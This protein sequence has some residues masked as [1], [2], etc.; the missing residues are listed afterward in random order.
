[1]T[2]PES[3][4]EMEASA[5]TAEAPDTTTEAPVSAIDIPDATEA[6]KDKARQPRPTDEFEPLRAK[7]REK[8]TVQARVVKWQKNGLDME[9]VDPI[10]DGK[11][12]PSAPTL[13]APTL[14]AFMSNDNIDHDPNRN[15][16]HYFGKTL[17]VKITSVKAKPGA[18]VAE[19]TLSHRAVLDEEARVAGH[20]AVKHLNVGDVIEVKVKNFD[21][22]NVKVDL[23]HGI[24]AVILLRDLSWQKVDH[25]YEI[26]KRGETVTAKIL[27]LDRGRREVRLGIRQLTA[28]PEFAMYAEYALG[29]T[30]KAKVVGI[31]HFGAEIELPNGLIA[32]IPISEIDWQRIGQVSEVLSI[33][34]RRVRCE[35]HERRFEGTPHHRKPKTAYRRSDACDR[36]YV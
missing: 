7:M 3:S 33:G 17:P 27:A 29:Q 28:D 16:A 26:L 1:M 6:P 11:P 2:N 13:K 25:P 9:I 4:P 23:G 8:A 35:T 30:Q 5:V 19:I 12:T 36:A 18:S 32:F 14:K 24:D 10:L 22:S 20:E 21:H 31:D 15:I 34:W